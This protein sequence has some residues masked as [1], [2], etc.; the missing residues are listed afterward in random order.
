ME[1]KEI[2]IKEEEEREEEK[3]ENDNVIRSEEEYFLEWH[4]V[5]QF[6]EEIITNKWK[7]TWE[8]K[9]ETISTSLLIFQEQ[10]TLLGPYLEG[11]I[12]PLTNCLIEILQQYQQEIFTKF[13]V[14]FL[15]SFLFLILRLFLFFCSFLYSYL[16]IFIEN[17]KYAISCNL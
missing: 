13:Q 14:S 8:L 16:F 3:E 11:I 12:V 17:G 4:N 1:K 7:E 6:I 15:F 9:W 5:N 10:P 2:K